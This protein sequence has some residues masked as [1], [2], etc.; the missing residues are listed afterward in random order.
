MRIALL[1]LDE[2]CLAVAAEALAAGV[3][4]VAGH[5]R[6]GEQNQLVTVCPQATWE[7][8]WETLLVGKRIDAILISRSLPTL[9]VDEIG[10]PAERREEQLRRCMQEQIPLVVFPPVCR[11]D[12][13]YELEV[14]RRD[15]R[16]IIIPWLPNWNHDAWNWLAEMLAE[17]SPLGKLEQF[18]WETNLS[19]RSRA[20]VLQTF[21]QDIAI[22]RRLFG[23]IRTVTAAASHA[24][25]HYDPFA[26]RANLPPLEQLGVQLG[27]A[28]NEVVRWNVMPAQGETLGTITLLGSAGRAELK[29]HRDPSQWAGML[30]RGNDRQEIAW[31]QPASLWQEISSAVNVVSNPRRDASTTVVFPE[32]LDLCRDL[33]AIEAIDRSLLKGRSVAVHAEET[34]EEESFKGTMAS[35]GC[36]VLLLVLLAFGGVLLV[37]GLQLPIRKFAIWRLWPVGLVVCILGFLLLQSLGVLVCKPAAEP[38]EKQS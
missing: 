4:V 18:R 27:V 17:N 34:S 12:F 29:L 23:A 21:A 38:S 7:P 20:S 5:G 10:T 14:Y 22:V 25:T 1:G 9:T 8:N 19:D 36:L 28:G 32:W 6:R 30:E 35:A 16:G 13:G 37:E 2:E 33:E 31:P 3:A 24:E 26:P 11:L 15:N